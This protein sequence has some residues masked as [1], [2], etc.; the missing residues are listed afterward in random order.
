MD[1]DTFFD[2]SLT[3]ALRVMIHPADVE[4]C[5][6]KLIAKLSFSQ[7][8]VSLLSLHENSFPLWI[9]IAFATCE[10][11]P[12]TDPL[13]SHIPSGNVNAVRFKSLGCH[14]LLPCCRHPAAKFKERAR[15]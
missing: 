11:H 5:R 13:V 12:L 7:E 14:P 3:T 10:F 2:E 4:T 1:G 9:E 15:R 6:L 8:E